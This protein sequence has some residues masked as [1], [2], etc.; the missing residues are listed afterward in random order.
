MNVYFSQSEF[1]HEMCYKTGAQV[2]TKVVRMI[3]TSG[4]KGFTMIEIIAV[5]VILGVLA[6]VAV[7]KYVDL[8]ANAKKMVAR[9]QVAELKGMLNTAWGKA[10]LFKGSAPEIEEVTGN[11]SMG[12]T[13]V[14]QNIGT[15]PDI[16]YYNWSASGNIVTISISA[17]G[18]D[19]DYND[20]GIWTLPK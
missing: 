14:E 12:A 18:S 2:T 11:A 20:V 19:T 13:G 17:R 3:R 8:M 6:A 1:W 15:A 9:G 4:Q 10:F 7:P 16:W 5:L